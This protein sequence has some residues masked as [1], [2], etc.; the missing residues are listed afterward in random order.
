MDLKTIV[1]WTIPEEISNELAQN[2]NA[3]IGVNLYRSSFEDGA[4]EKLNENPISL[5]ILTYE[6]VQVPITVKDSFYYLIRFVRPDNSES[7]YYIAYTQLS[8]KELRLGQQLRNTLS[9]FI[10]C[11][12]SD[13]DI[14][15]GLQYG[16]KIFNEIPTKTYFKLS[17]LPP[18]LEPIILTLSALFAFMNKYIPVAFTDFTYSDNGLTLT[19]DRGTKLKNIMEE[20][21]KFI[22]KYIAPFKWNYTGMGSGLG[23]IPLP[24]SLGGKM[25]GQLLEILNLYMVV[26]R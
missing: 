25:S 22:D 19:Y 1:Y 18:T 26:G 7:K 12:L 2:N 3:Y 24:L 20:M 11:S 16:L 21:N 14:A 15:A 10:S 23:T 9:S 4:Y 5:Q 17:L 6:D 13:A 8:P